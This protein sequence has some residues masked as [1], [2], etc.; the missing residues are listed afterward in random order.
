MADP[1]TL[2]AAQQANLG[3]GDNPFLGQ[4]NPYVQ[5][6]INTAG[7]NMVDQYNL[8]QQPAFNAAM[9][10]S[11]SFGNAG[12]Q[13][14][15]NQ[16]QNMLQQNLGNL[17]NSMLGQDYSNQQNMYQWQQGQL[18]NQSQ[19]SQTLA[20]QQNQWQQ[21]FDTSNNQWNLGF[22]R[23]V[24]NDAY[25]QNM[26]NLQAGMGLLGSMQGYNANDLTNAN[27]QQNTPLN[28]WQQFANQANGIGQGY[29]TTTGQLGTTSNPFGAALGGAQLG[30]AFGNAWNSNSGGSVTGGSPY[31][32]T[33]Y[34]QS[35]YNLT[36]GDPSYGGYSTPAGGSTLGLGTL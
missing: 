33:P 25:S 15:N 22:N 12:V 31:A 7:Q 28:Y 24:Y 20:N 9:A 16:A 13:Q 11:G 35:P 17:S 4:S 27:T 32:G 36:N 21:Q 5:G 18:Q 14:M 3:M 23:N 8:T 29:G 26:E 6:M 1:T 10:N 34:S 30:T 2:T 19:F